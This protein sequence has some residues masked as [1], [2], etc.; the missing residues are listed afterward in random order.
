MKTKKT[1][2]VELSFLYFKLR[3]LFNYGYMKYLFFRNLIAYVCD[4]SDYQM[5]RRVFEDLCRRNVFT[6]RQTEHNIVYCFNP[7][8]KMIDETPNIKIDWS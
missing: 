1:E 8:N 3:N 2:F 6:I 5:I 7:T 4:I